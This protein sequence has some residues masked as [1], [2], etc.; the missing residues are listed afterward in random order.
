MNQSGKN[1]SGYIAIIGALSYLVAF[2]I[3]RS[4]IFSLSV[5]RENVVAVEGFWFVL[6]WFEIAGWES[7]IPM[8]ILLKVIFCVASAVGSICL[9]IIFAGFGRTLRRTEGRKALIPVVSSIVGAFAS[10][11]AYLGVLIF[12]LTNSSDLQGLI[13]SGVIT[14]IGAQAESVIP[15]LTM[16]LVFGGILVS[17][18]GVGLISLQNPGNLLPQPARYLGLITGV[19]GLSYLSGI[20][21]LDLNVLGDLRLLIMPAQYILV[22]GFLL[23]IEWLFL[24]GF[25]MTRNDQELSKDG[26][27]SSQVPPSSN[28]VMSLVFFIAGLLVLVSIII[29]ILFPLASPGADIYQFLLDWSNVVNARTIHSL[30]VVFGVFMILLATTAFYVQPKD[31]SKGRVDRLQIFLV[32]FGALIAVKALS[33]FSMVK[34]HAMNFMDAPPAALP[35]IAAGASRI[36]ANAML[37]MTLGG[38]LILTLGVGIISVRALK[39]SEFRIQRTL[40][41]IS[42][43]LGFGFIG[44][45]FADPIFSVALTIAKVSGIAL[46]LW[47]FSLGTY[48]WKRQNR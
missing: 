8:G 10:I 24:A 46:S 47:M 3:N 41:F 42:A 6:E 35:G 13:P 40:G 16:F 23:M 36:V 18:L 27:A 1:K 48:Y 4:P 43:I 37:P 34:Y 21:I 25:T 5:V 30:V 22:L 44:L 39:S 28:R 33:D 32:H 12:T 9:I 17:V 15:L 19:L 2:T 14:A 20:P 45:L 26:S 29:D 7:L 11:I 31:Y 38:F